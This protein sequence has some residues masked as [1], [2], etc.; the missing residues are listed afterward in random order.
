MPSLLAVSAA[1]SVELTS[2]GTST[3]SGSPVD[4]DRLEALHHA[5]GLH[6][7]R[8]RADLQHAVGRA[9][10]ELVEEDLRHRL[11]VV[12]AGVHEQVLEARPA[13]D[14]GDDGRHLDEVRPGSDDGQDAS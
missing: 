13:L 4:D 1:A 9:D 14:L 3:R 7:V 12:L 8:A 5:R 10:P 11:V 6:G 2:P